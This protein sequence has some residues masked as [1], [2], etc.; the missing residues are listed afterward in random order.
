MRIACAP[1]I[2]PELTGRTI[3]S[4]KTTTVPKRRTVPATGRDLSATVVVAGKKTIPET[5]REN[6]D[7]IGADWGRNVRFARYHSAYT[8]H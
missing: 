3:M 8:P 1:G 6:E 7:F 2:V 4:T 5:R